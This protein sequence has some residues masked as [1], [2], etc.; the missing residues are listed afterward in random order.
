MSYLAWLIEFSSLK[1]WKLVAL[2]AYAYVAYE[3][4]CIRTQC[5]LSLLQL[6]IL[7]I[8]SFTR[9]NSYYNMDSYIDAIIGPYVHGKSV[10]NPSGYSY[11][12]GLSAIGGGSYPLESTACNKQ[13]KLDVGY[14]FGVKASYRHRRCTYV[15][16]YN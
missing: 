16:K 1:I 6:S 5:L 15:Y 12:S 10:Y 11:A 13:H 7:S 14:Q 2:P 4:L 9:P 3:S 8:G